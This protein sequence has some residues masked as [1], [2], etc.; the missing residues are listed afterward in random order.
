[1]KNSAM[2]SK[3]IGKS[4]ASKLRPWRNNLEIFNSNMMYFSPNPDLNSLI[5]E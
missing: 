5:L 2:K 4:S 3:S 1:M